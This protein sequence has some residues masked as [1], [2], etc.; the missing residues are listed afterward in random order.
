ML[1]TTEKKKSEMHKTTATTTTRTTRKIKGKKRRERN[2]RA[3][4][5]RLEEAS[6]KGIKMMMVLREQYVEM[7]HV[8][9]VHSGKQQP[10]NQPTNQPPPPTALI[11]MVEKHDDIAKANRSRIP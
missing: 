8:V 7:F 9:C 11:S 4:N 6:E 5:T 2:C 10:T 1:E 3:V